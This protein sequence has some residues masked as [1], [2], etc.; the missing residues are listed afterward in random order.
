[1]P[2][3]SPPAI[4]N[5]SNAIHYPT[6]DEWN[7]EIQQA[8]GNKNS[9]SINYVGNHGS[10]LA[11]QNPAVNAYCNVACYAALGVTSFAGLPA[12][13]TDPRFSTV[14]EVSSPGVSNYN[15]VTV[16]FTRRVST[17]FQMQANYTWSHALD[18]I[19]NGGFLPFSAAT[20][21]SVLAPQD[22]FNLKLY[23]Y[24]NADYDARHQ[25]NLSYVWHTPKLHNFLW[26]A[27][28]DWTVSETLFTHNGYPFTAIDGATTAALGA[29]NYGPAP[30]LGL[31]VFAND[32]VGPLSCSPRDAFTV[33]GTATPCMTASEFTSP[34]TPGGVGTFGR[35]RRNQIYG[36]W[37]FDTDLTL[38]KN[39]R[40]PHWESAE[41]QV[42]AQAF[43]ILNHPNFDQPVGDIGNPQ[44][45]TSIRTLSTPT[46]IFG[47]FLGANAAPR[48]LQ[49]RGQLTF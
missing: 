35:E 38:M 14:T 41:F 40:V 4:T 49:I 17:S 30:G 21:I 10:H 47:S 9:I 18:D 1:V 43:N 22:P 11:L 12:G 44:F 23:N 20:N 29:F 37:F 5:P 46:S 33:A 32:L 28:L 42:G 48:A 6:Y 27:L 15:G 36:P 19:S 2:A 8:I 39:F 34:V 24:G 7:F 13:P 16:S 31:N 26:N 45:G 3:F 25:F